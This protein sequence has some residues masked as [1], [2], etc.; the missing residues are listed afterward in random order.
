L[1]L[2]IIAFVLEII[3]MLIQGNEGKQGLG[4][5]KDGVFVAVYGILL[6]IAVPEAAA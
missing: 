6:I 5:V 1:F 3:V 2:A 4:A